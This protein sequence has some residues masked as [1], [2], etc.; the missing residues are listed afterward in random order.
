MNSTPR[1]WSNLLGNWK[2]SLI[3]HFVVTSIVF[4]LFLYVFVTKTYP[5]GSK[6]L[7]D[8][9]WNQGFF[10]TKMGIPGYLLFYF[11]IYAPIQEYFFR[12]LILNRLLKFRMDQYLAIFISA[13]L[14]AITRIFYPYP[15][16]II[17][18]TF[19]MGIIFGI[20]YVQNKSVVILSVFHF[21]WAVMAISINLF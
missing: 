10:L 21:L 17:L 18:V 7:D 3:Y 11:F 15:L 14:F 12:G 16:G 2:G 20:D 19:I 4:F 1:I 13:S 6:V 5:D 9:G 8:R